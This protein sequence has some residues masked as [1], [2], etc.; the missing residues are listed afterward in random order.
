MPKTLCYFQNSWLKNA[1]HKKWIR[2]K[3]S[4]TAIYQYCS[5]DNKVGNMG[6]LALKSHILS[7]RH[8]QR[9]S[10]SNVASLLT[11]QQDQ[12]DQKGKKSNEPASKE[13]T[14]ND[15]LKRN[16]LQWTNFS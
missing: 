15:Q 1:Q 12:S 11:L 8:K 16:N 9:T 2:K 3:D 6:E 4:D 7:N 14:S 10:L 13:T 5:R